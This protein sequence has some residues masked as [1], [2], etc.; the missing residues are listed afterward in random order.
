MNE[1][2]RLEIQGQDAQSAAD[3]IQKAMAEIFGGEPV[4]S[5]PE[6]S[7]AEDKT[8]G[9]VDYIL[10]ALAIP[11]ALVATIDLATRVD[12]VEKVE[13]VMTYAE[14]LE[15]KLPK[16]EVNIV[17]GGVSFSLKNTTPEDLTNAIAEHQRRSK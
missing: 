3:S 1:S 7:V 15:K 5:Q 13:Q 11:P 17:V 16:F 10:I 14:Q 4:R 6:R 2:F 9:I 8:K 12:V